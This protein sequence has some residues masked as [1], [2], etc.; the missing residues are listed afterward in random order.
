MLASEQR[1]LGVALLGKS[2]FSELILTQAYAWEQPG[3]L[4]QSQGSD[5]AAI[6][7][8]L[9][10]LMWEKENKVVQSLWK[11]DTAQMWSTPSFLGS[12][13]S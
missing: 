11:K 13:D 2:C 1:T 6:P 4:H 10:R 9:L 5:K 3:G 7:S 12:C 8:L